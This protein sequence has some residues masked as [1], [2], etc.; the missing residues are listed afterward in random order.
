VGF[1]L[2]WGV[3]LLH[4]RGVAGAGRVALIAGIVVVTL[5]L[6][7]TFYA[8]SVPAGGMAS[9]I[10]RHL[11]LR[12]PHLALAT[13]SLGATAAT[14]LAALAILFFSYVGIATAT[15]AGDETRDPGRTVP[16][17]LL[18]AVGIVTTIYVALNLAIYRAVPW[19]S[20]GLLGSRPATAAYTSVTG[21]LTLVVPAWVGVVLSLAT[22]FIVA[23]TIVPLFLAQSR[24]VY[25]WAADELIPHWFAR[26]APRFGTPVTALTIGAAAGSLALLESI[27]FGFAFGV[28]MRVLSA[29]VV[30]VLVGIALCRGSFARRILGGALAAIA[31]ALIGSIVVAAARAPLYAQPAF[32]ALVVAAVALVILMR[33]AAGERRRSAG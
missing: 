17:A 13:R 18:I 28:A 32:Q 21:L 5:A 7:I 6:G 27:A 8:A 10:A 16:R 29:M 30:L 11:D 25:A 4:V 12:T 22:A 19:T 23:K 33:N 2:I 20:I 14:D 15:Q 24:W 26:V 1:A 9:A 31:L 3:W